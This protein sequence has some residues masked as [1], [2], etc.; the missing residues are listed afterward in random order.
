MKLFANDASVRAVRA[1]E[2]NRGTMKKLPVIAVVLVLALTLAALGAGAPRAAAEEGVAL[3]I[4]YDTSGSMREMVKDADGKQAPKYVIANRAL[5]SIA[6]RIQGFATNS[7]N[8]SR[9]VEAGVFIFDRDNAKEAVKYGS[10]DPAAIENW[11]RHF[12]KP[13]G[14][15]PLGNALTTATTIISP[16]PQKSHFVLTKEVFI[17]GSYPRKPASPCD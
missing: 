15:T 5:I 16:M 10:F 2:K 9:K 6:R 14:N 7:A 4:V 1:A 13:G 17:V 12:S 3:A 8:G 11:A